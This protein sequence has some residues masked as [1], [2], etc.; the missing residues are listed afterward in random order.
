MIHVVMQLSPNCRGSEFNS[1]GF[2]EPVAPSHIVDP[3]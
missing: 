1:A 3:H 2:T